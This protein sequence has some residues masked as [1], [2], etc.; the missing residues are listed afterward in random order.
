METPAGGNMP[1]SRTSAVSWTDKSGNLWLFS[2]WGQGN[3]FF[4]D[5][6]TYPLNDVWEYGHPRP[7]CRQRPHRFSARHLAPT[8]AAVR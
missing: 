6:E 5:V 4:S 2:G 8:T 3:S 1:G 7:R